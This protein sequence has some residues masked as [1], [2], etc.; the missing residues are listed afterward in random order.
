MKKITSIFLL[1]FLNMLS[2]GQTLLTKGNLDFFFDNTEFA[3]SSY[4]FDQTMSGLHLRPEIGIGW[5][6]KHAIYTG[7][8]LLKKMG[9]NSTIDQTVFLAYYQY[10]DKNTFFQ[11]G[12]FAKNNLFDDYSSFFFQDSVKY[13]RPA[14]NGLYLKK[15]DKSRYYKLWLDWTGLQS[16]TVRESFFLGATAYN[17]FNKNLFAD[18]QMY[19]FHYAGTR[20][21]LP[22]QHVCENI[23]AQASVGY[24]Y[25]DKNWNKIIVS[26]G[27]L[28][29]YERNRKYLNDPYIPIGFVRRVDVE[30][31]RWGTENLIYSGKRR[32][33]LYNEFGNQLYWGNPF[34]RGSFYWQNKLYWN[35]IKN[36]NVTGQLS[37]RNHISQ[38]RVYTEQLFTL[39]ATIGN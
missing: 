14:V 4:T 23:L 39:S 11:V 21:S 35:V 30:Y 33:K 24:K 17:E 7:V 8:D 1:T 34:L 27:I 18:F 38:G 15:G 25:S 10:K 2:F 22:D 26:A 6:K 32:M 19:V 9:S 13:Y 3:G 20:P 28:A 31:K 29:G 37:V 36:R 16:P 12:S 5:D